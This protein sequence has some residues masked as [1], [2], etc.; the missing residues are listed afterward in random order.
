[1]TESPTTAPPAAPA[2][3]GADA[4]APAAEHRTVIEP[5]GG[6]RLVDVG[7]LWRYRELLFA[8]A[9]RD[10]Q[11]RYK[12]TLLGVAWA[13]LQ[14]AMLMVVFTVF[15]GRLAGV[16]TGG[17]PGPL[18]FLT[19]VLP[20]T[21]FAGALTAGSNSVV[22]SEHLISKIYFPRLAVPLAA[23]S[24]AVVDFLIACGLLAVFL[25]YCVAVPGYFAFEPTWNLML[26]PVVVVI[27]GTLATGLG[28]LFAALNV[29]YR[30]V[31]YVLPFLIQLGMFATPTIYSRPTAADGEAVRWLLILNP[32]TSLV[33]AFRNCLLGGPIP[34]AGLGVAAAAAVVV[35]VA[36]CLYFRKVEDTFADKI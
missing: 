29:S 25:L 14:P 17:I 23:V 34:W 9:R 36:G 10:L 33:E 24:A 21:F 1:M 30:D 15:F 11:V 13:V 31:R 19:G 22:G 4:P 7:E 35:F 2:P 27:I 6:W 3:A 32:M 28:T 16:G 26:L 8:L 12:Q 5:G 18:F 20:W